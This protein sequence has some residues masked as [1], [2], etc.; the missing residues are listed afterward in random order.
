MEARRPSDNIWLI[1]ATNDAEDLEVE[2]D[3]NINKKDK[4]YICFFSFNCEHPKKIHKM[5]TIPTRKIGNTS[6]GSLGFGAMGLAVFYA[7]QK[8]VNELLLECIKQGATMI[9]TADI[10]SPLKLQR[11]GFNEEQVGQFFK[12]YPGSREKIF[13]PPNSSTLGLQKIP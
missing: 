10:Y 7:D 4:F 1:S 8:V 6:V 5:T 13:W 3:F 11:L 9:D 2:Q 12:D